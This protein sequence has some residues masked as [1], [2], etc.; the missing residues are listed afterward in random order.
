MGHVITKASKGQDACA[1][2]VEHELWCWGLNSYGNAGRAGT[3]GIP[4]LVP[5]FEDRQIASVDVGEGLTCAIEATGEAWCWGR[6]HNGQLGQHPNGM[7]TSMTPVRVGSGTEGAFTHVTAGSMVAC[8]IHTNGSVACQG[9]CTFGA[10]GDGTTI[11]RVGLHWV[12]LPQVVRRWDW[13]RDIHVCAI[14]DDRSVACWGSNAQGQIG[15]NSTTDAI[16]PQVV[17]PP[18]SRS[19]TQSWPRPIP[20][21]GTPPARHG[22]GAGTTT[23]SSG[24]GTPIVRNNSRPPRC[25]HIRA[26][27]A[28]A[29]LGAS[30]TCR[31]VPSRCVP[32]TPM[33][34]SRAGGCG[35]TI[36]L[37]MA[38]L[39]TPMDMIG[40]V[41]RAPRSS[42]IMVG[43][44]HILPEEVSL[45]RTLRPVGWGLT[46]QSIA[47]L[48][49]SMVFDRA[50][51]ALK[52][53]GTSTP[54]RT[55]TVRL[56]GPNGPM[57]CPSTS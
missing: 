11:D 47:N 46:V 4:R 42:V 14:L 39:G 53:D 57:F 29:P 24:T 6:N 56:Q 27:R 28:S 43:W 25:S 40:S 17:L 35:P 41:H 7:S 50:T 10:L 26:P 8:F 13:M 16:T 30:S 37:A 18:G 3:S 33:A 55:I 45:N 2:N 34:W 15:N 23:V 38:Y 9:H 52:Y 54:T 19:S 44:S 32:C 21:H 12:H 49:A 22:A 5:A 31:P 48:T 1:I 36:P 20:V 51:G